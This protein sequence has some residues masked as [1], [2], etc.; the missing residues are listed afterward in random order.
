MLHAGIGSRSGHRDGGP[1][2][3]RSASRARPARQRQAL[4]CPSILRGGYK[5]DASFPEAGAKQKT[6]ILPKMSESRVRH[7]SSIQKTA[8]GRLAG[9][10]FSRTPPKGATFELRPH[11]GR[12][13]WQCHSAW[14]VTHQ[15]SAAASSREQQPWHASRPISP[16]PTKDSVPCRKVWDPQTPRRPQR[17]QMRCLD[18]TSFNSQ[19][20]PYVLGTYCGAQPCCAPGTRRPA[21]QS[22]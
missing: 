21:K 13:R 15:G 22:S 8:P 5:L 18:R 9:R 20:T 16:G 19:F 6:R 2:G 17:S 4:S 7:G 3:K 11:G 14:P 1:S 10:T 12:S